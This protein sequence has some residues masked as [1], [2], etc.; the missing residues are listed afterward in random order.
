MKKN[1]FSIE[2]YLPTEDSLK[3]GYDNPE[4]HKAWESVKSQLD[5][6]L[7]IAF[8]GTASAGKTSGISQS[9]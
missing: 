5:E 6:E 1:E 9:S 3:K 4:F 8:L 7:V 2:D